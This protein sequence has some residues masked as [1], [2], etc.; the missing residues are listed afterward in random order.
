MNDRSDRFSDYGERAMRF[1]GEAWERGKNTRF[2]Q[3]F[4]NG[5]NEAANMAV[6]AITAKTDALKSR[7]GS[8]K[9]LSS[10]EQAVY[11]E[12]DTLK[13]ELHEAFIK[14]WQPASE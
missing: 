2:D 13:A 14:F 8:G 9:G 1:L 5:F 11:A 7:M 6:D 10:A 4:A 3:E 12:L